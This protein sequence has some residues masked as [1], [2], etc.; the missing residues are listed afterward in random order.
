MKKLTILIAILTLLGVGSVYY[1]ECR[2]EKV[3]IMDK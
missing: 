2:I 1:Q 3:Y